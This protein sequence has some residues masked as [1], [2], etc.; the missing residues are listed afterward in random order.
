[1][2]EIVRA[3]RHRELFLVSVYMLKWPDVRRHYRRAIAEGRLVRDLETQLARQLMP[4][5]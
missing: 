2:R 3:T 4:R 5:Q 1:M